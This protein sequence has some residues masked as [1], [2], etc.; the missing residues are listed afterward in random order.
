MAGAIS[1]A[2]IASLIAMAASAAMQYK[3]STDAAK[4][5]TAQTQLALQRQTDLQ[6]QAEAKA[7]GQAE[8]FAA[9]ERA[10]AQQTIEQELT[11]EFIKPVENSAEMNAKATTTQGNVSDDYTTAKATSTVNLAKNARMLAGLLGKTTAAGRLRQNEAIDMANTA[12]GIDRL[13]SFSRGQAGADQ[14]AIQAA[15]QPN[16]GLQLAG[17]LLGAVG[18]YGLS[19]GF[20]GATTAAAPSLGGGG[21]FSGIGTQ[22]NGLTLAGGN[23]LPIPNL[24]RRMP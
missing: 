18:S 9:P 14:I 1:G 7:L 15:G 17:G 10:D 8:E 2:T 16:A 3:A 4:R 20:K 5:S 19:G 12:A 11:D 13:G 21:G 6:R 22:A 24:L 23:G